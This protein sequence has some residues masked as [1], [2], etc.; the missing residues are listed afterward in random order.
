[1]PID[2]STVLIGPRSTAGAMY[3]RVEPWLRSRDCWR[4][5]EILVSDPEARESNGEVELATRDVEENMELLAGWQSIY[6]GFNSPSLTFGLQFDASRAS[7]ARFSYT[8]VYV[9]MQKMY[10]LHAGSMPNCFYE[11]LAGIASANKAVGGFGGFEAE[12][13][14]PSP[15]Q[16]YRRL[17]ARPD[18]A[19]S[20][21]D[22]H[23]VAAQRAPSLTRWLEDYL[24]I[25]AAGFVFYLH[26]E[27]YAMSCKFGQSGSA[28]DR[29]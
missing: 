22:L 11:L 17:L 21:F 1:M 6:A 28:S 8:T 9:E 7:D 4:C 14:Q 18:D 13:R 27:F 29:L 19:A 2:F 12:L 3:E 5:E 15:E 16:A 26:R 23:M 10:D 24:E 20:R 25:E